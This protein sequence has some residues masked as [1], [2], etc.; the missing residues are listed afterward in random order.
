MNK[1]SLNLYLQK[2]EADAD[3]KDKYRK[4]FEEVQGKI[5]SR[6]Y[7]VKATKR[8]VVQI[9]IPSEKANLMYD[10]LIEFPF[11]KSDGSYK[12]FRNSEI[13]V[14]SNCP[15]FVYMNA[16]V[17]ERKGFLITWAK[18]L[19][20][21]ETLAPPPDDKKEEEL[22]KDVRYEKSL[23]FAALYL[24]KFNA[25]QILTFLNNADAMP[26]NE[27]IVRFIKTSDWAMEKRGK[28][29]QAELKKKEVQRAVK[30]IIPHHKGSLSVKK[31]SSVKVSGKSSHISKISSQARSSRIKHI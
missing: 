10:V 5:L 25:I 7:F 22:Q 28:A 30:N 2:V 12:N 16:R 15:S 1:L 9:K 3:T 17:F 20:N 13:R 19:Y 27:N 11:G 6:W 24:D 31:I 8:I 21:K 18:D 26:N 4:R 23:Y 14:F 29:Y